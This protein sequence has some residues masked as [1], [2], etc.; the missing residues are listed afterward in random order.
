MKVKQTRPFS[1]CSNKHEAARKELKERIAR[2]S[3]MLAA[4]EQE[5]ARKE[6]KGAKRF[7]TLGLTLLALEAARKE[8]KATLCSLTNAT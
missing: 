8:L 5:A 4:I 6:L 1:P 7:A 2:A 3:E